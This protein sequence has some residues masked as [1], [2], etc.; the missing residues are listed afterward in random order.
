MRRNSLYSIFMVL[1]LAGCG[2]GRE[3]QPIAMQEAFFQ[4]ELAE[5]SR[6]YA[7]SADQSQLYWKGT[8]LLY[9]RSHEGTLE[10]KEGKLYLKEGKLLGGKV[11]MDMNSIKVTDI[12]PDQPVPLRNLTKHLKEDFA[13]R[14]YGISTFEFSHV[15]YLRPD[16]LILQGNLRIKNKVQP[17]SITATQS[18]DEGLR[19]FESEF[20]ID[21][22][23]WDIGTQGS[24]LEK[25]WTEK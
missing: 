7:L 13:V 5:G 11:T 24:W 20:V 23:A 22:F 16:S 4:V 9:T 12:P 18:T 6:A 10:V 21:R 25:W 15:D 19:Y 8:K 17:I 14:K 1:L 2:M 3:Q